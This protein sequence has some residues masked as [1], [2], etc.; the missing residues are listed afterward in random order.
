VSAE[1]L[2]RAL[3]LDLGQARRLGRQRIFPPSQGISR[4]QFVL[5]PEAAETVLFI[6]FAIEPAMRVDELTALLG[7]GQMAE[8]G[9]H[10]KAPTVIFDDVLPQD[11]Q[12]GCAVLARLTADHPLV[13]VVD[14]VVLY[15]RD[16]RS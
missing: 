5:G 1:D 4:L 9:P 7:P 12:R 2:A 14:V 11:A 6:E 15:P 3:N 13:S 10:Q 8:P 16:A